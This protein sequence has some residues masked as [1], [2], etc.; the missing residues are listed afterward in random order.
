MKIG[1]CFKIKMVRKDS[2]DVI[3]EVLTISSDDQWVSA[4]IL[5]PVLLA[6]KLNPMG[7]IRIHIGS[8]DIEVLGNNEDEAIRAIYG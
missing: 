5:H 4:K 3:Y 7:A 2:K 6:D 8:L 1:D